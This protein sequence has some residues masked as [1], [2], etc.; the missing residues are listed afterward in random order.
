MKDSEVHQA[1]LIIVTTGLKTGG[2]ERMLVKLLTRVDRKRYVPVVVSLTGSGTQGEHL[3]RLGIECVYPSL[4]GI[5]GLAWL[6][7]STMKRIGRGRPVLLQGWMYHGCFFAAVLHWLTRDRAS[8]LWSIRHSLHDLSKEKLSVRLMLRALARLSHR[9]AVCVYPSKVAAAQHADIGIRC[10]TTAIVANGFELERFRVP[11]AE[12]RNS[13]RERLGAAADDCVIVHVARFHP[14]KDH[15]GLLRAF[16]DALRRAPRLRLIMA[17]QG[18]VGQNPPL[19]AIVEELGVSRHVTMLGELADV[20][21]LLAAG[22][23]FCLSSKWGEAFPNALGEAMAMG[24]PAICT[25]VGDCREI[26]GAAGWVLSV[27]DSSAL[28]D[29]MTQLAGLSEEERRRIGRRARERVEQHYDLGK[30]VAAYE[31]VYAAQLARQ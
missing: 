7:R 4:R 24:L 17:G 27:D 29:A 8:L 23:G 30:C 15:A 5:A 11:N 16:A 6:L 25:D 3:H 13:A 31:Q 19:A 22:D 10:G 14:M 9:V 12:Y 2:A 1:E 18:V 21:D 28:A 20:R 26:V